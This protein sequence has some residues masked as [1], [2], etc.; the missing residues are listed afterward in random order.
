MEPTQVGSGE[1]VISTSVEYELEDEEEEEVVVV[2]LNVEELVSVE[3][4]KSS[5]TVMDEVDISVLFSLK[6]LPP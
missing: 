6:L 5:G 2:V 3:E 4:L 1:V